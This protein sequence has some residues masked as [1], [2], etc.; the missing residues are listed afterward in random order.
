MI[1]NTPF[2]QFVRGEITLGKT[3]IFGKN[4][5]QSIATRLV[6]GA[7]Y[8][9]GN[10]SALPFEKHFYGGGANSLRGW[11]AR[12]VGPGL[13]P[14]DTSFVI[15]NQTGDMRLEANIEYRFDMFWKVA[16]AVFIDAGNVWTLKDDNTEEGRLAMFRWDTFAESIAANWGVG[17]R[18]DFGF[19]LLRL[20]MGMK[21]HDPARNTKWIN[22]GEWLTKGNYALHF[23]VGYPF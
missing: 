17:L 21:V 5:G 12:T 13:S 15:P 14:M 7:G 3:W 10:S 19:L 22:P 1:W 2:S 4:D 8:A 23:G 20:D 6:V 11:Q 16:G 18:L 9:Y